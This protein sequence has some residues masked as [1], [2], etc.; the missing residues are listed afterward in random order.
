[1]GYASLARYSEGLVSAQ[2]VTS[3]PLHIMRR[4]PHIIFHLRIVQ[5]VRQCTRLYRVLNSCRRREP[6]LSHT[7]FIISSSRAGIN[8]IETHTAEHLDAIYS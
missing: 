1:M 6:T 4:T 5:R 3:V 8:H 2:Y 7:H